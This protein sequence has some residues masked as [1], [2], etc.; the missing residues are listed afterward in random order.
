MAIIGNPIT[1]GKG[2]GSGMLPQL[3]VTGPTTGSTVVATNGSESVTLVESNG[4]W[5]GDLTKYGTWTVTATLG[6]NTATDTITISEVKQYTMTLA[7]FTATIS[8]T[9]P[10]GS[11]VTVTKDG[12]TVNTHTAT[13]SAIAVSVHETG[14]YT[15]TATSGSDTASNTAS[16]TADGQSVSIS[17]SFIPED[18]ND[19]TWAQISEVSQAGTGDTYWDVGDTKAITLNGTIGTKSYSNVTLYLFILHFNM[20]VNKSTADNNIIWGGFKTAKSGG[21]DVCLD[22]SAYNTDKYDG[23]KYFNMNHNGTNSG[24]E[25]TAG[26]YGTNYGGWKG[27]DLRYD[28]LGATNTQPSQY[29]Q[30]KNTSNVGYDATQAA[31]TSPLSNTLMAALPSDFRNVLRLW[32]RWMDS[33][34]NKSN[35]DANVTSCVDAGISLLTE[36][37]VFGTRSYAN[38]YEQNHQVQCAYYVA[39]NS[40]VKYRQSSTG[41]SAMWWESSAYYNSV[42][43]FCIVGTGGNASNIGACRACGL[44]PAFKT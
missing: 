25:G 39:G 16:I 41:T 44:A 30:K 20:P 43:S 34:G 28:I 40:K 22:D 15:V 10:S 12:T 2:G 35:V 32:T 29:N 37:E 3:V 27:T 33:K 4:T 23:T 21:I 1:F 26:W 19:A 38:Q 24:S 9:A 7:Y 13:G 31:I 14:T 18:V 42:N 11:T 17:L 36:F 6:S 8:V 5:T